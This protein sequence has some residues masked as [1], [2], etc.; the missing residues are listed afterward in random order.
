MPIAKPVITDHRN[1]EMAH[2]LRLKALTPLPETQ[3]Q[4][5]AR[6]WLIALFVPLYVHIHEV[7]RHKGK[8]HIYRKQNE[9]NNWT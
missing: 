8:T 5:P 1:G 3:V 7:H 4:S 6:T 2:R 9:K